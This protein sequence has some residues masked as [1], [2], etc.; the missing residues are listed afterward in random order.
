MNTQF[1]QKNLTTH[2]T[3]N[4]TA[5]KISIA[6]DHSKVLTAL[7]EALPS[8]RSKK[9]ISTAAC[10]LALGS[11]VIQNAYADATFYTADNTNTTVE[12]IGLSTSNLGN[13]VLS[14][15]SILT[16][17]SNIY[18]YSVVLFRPTQSGIYTFGQIDSLYDTVMI[19]YNG[20]FDPTLPGQGALVGNDD[21]PQSAHQS[22]VGSTVSTLCKTSSYCPQVSFEVVAGQV[23]SLLVSVFNTSYPFTIPFDFYSSAPGQFASVDDIGPIDINADF[24]LAS[25]LDLTVKP[26][27]E[28]GTL[29]LDEANKT[30]SQ[31]FIADD[32]ATNTIDQFGNDSILSGVISDAVAGEAAPITITNSGVGGSVSFSAAQA[33][34]GSTT[35]NQGSTLAL[36]DNGD[37]SISSQLN[38]NGV[39]AT[40][41]ITNI[42]DSG[43]T[44]QNLAGVADSKIILA[45][46]T[47]TVANSDDTTYGG[48]FDASAGALR[49]IG[50]GN[51]TL[52]GKTH[53]LGAT[54]L[55]EGQLTLDGINGGAQLVSNI[56]GQTDTTLNLKN[57]AVLTGWIDPTN[58]NIDNTSLWNMTDDSIINHFNNAGTLRIATPTND[59]FKTLTIQGDYQSNNGT[60]I[61]NTHLGSDNSATDK[62]TINGNAS[63]N[64]LVKINNI[65][66][67]GA[68]TEN[69]IKIID[70]QGQ[71]TS[72]FSLANTVVAGAY[73]YKLTHKSSL[74]EWYLSSNIADILPSDPSDSNSNYSNLPDLGWLANNGLTPNTS[75]YRPDAGVN[76]GNQRGIINGMI[77]GLGNNMTGAIGAGSS[78][79][80]R[81]AARLTGANIATKDASATSQKSNSLWSFVA[82]NRTT[83]HTGNNQIDYTADS[84]S[85]QIG[86]DTSFDIGD[87]LLQ[88]GLMTAYGTVKTDSQNMLTRSTGKGRVSGYSFGV[89]G[90]WYAN[91]ESNLSPYIDG[92]LTHGRYDNEVTILSNPTNKYK[93]NAT[94]ITLQGGYPIALGSKVIVEPQAQIS[95]LHYSSNDYIDHTNTRVSN[96]LKGNVISRVGAYV[97]ASDTRIKP[98]AAMNLWYDGTRSAVKYNGVE[99]SSDKKGLILEAKVGFQAKATP[100]LTFWGEVGIRKGKNNHKEIGGSVGLR[101]QF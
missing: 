74:K 34:T 33:Y 60:L 91:K 69:G 3:H 49:K 77:P 2:A 36:I 16:L 57:G 30:Y 21:T 90:T 45:G 12:T 5:S 55:D 15:P 32:S 95:Y 18:P 75:I 28:G 43:T 14:N 42:T 78:G 51:L 1:T 29:R 23:Y 46:K 70:I 61:L 7:R 63:G 50:S 98:Y 68:Q 87:G 62:L 37:I 54:L 85:L 31:D 76:L 94:S 65:G 92:Y 58:V 13:G 44:V 72:N 79:G 41:D 80:M 101:Y 27:F 11:G 48:D 53:Y 17:G 25:N 39:G 97:Y 81:A 38:L 26:I 86:G 47:L 24:Y 71:S 19:L 40:F 67:T 89:Y 59:N 84:N 96:T 88:I 8:T 93:S 82:V 35:I 64:T 4:A 20:V 52:S 6:P 56:I 22:I 66:G 10:A 73:E 100:D 99:L 9:I 83:G